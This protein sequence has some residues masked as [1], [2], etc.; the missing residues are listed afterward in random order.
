MNNSKIVFLINDQARAIRCVYE[1]ESPQG[2]KEYI[3]KTLD[4]SIQPD[5][6]VVVE[7]GTRHGYTTVKVTEVDVPVDF[8]DNTDLKWIVG[9]VDLAKF[10][11]V[12]T[13]EQEAIT[14][15][16]QAE[17]RRQRA[18]L[19]ATMFKDHEATMASLALTTKTLPAE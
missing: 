18:E 8:N 17:L 7:T 12:K 2:S 14:A 1:N 11:Q 3:F 4:Q 19:R 6:I 10:K 16:Q 13:Q 15:V 5:D 9:R